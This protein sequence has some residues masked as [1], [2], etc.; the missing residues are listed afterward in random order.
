MN[1]AVVFFLAVLIAASAACGVR[2]EETTDKFGRFGRITLY[3]P[4]P[5]PAHVALFVSGDGG[6]NLGVVDMA[7]E[8]A[9]LDTLV[10]GVD[11]THYLKQLESASEQCVYPAADFELL[12]KYVQKKLGFPRYITPVMIGY[13]SGATL[14]YAALVQAPSN[15]FRGAISLSFC[16]DIDLSK[17]LCRGSGLR[18]TR[19]H[20]GKGSVLLPA[21]HLAVPWVVLQGAVDQVC[22]AGK[23]QDYVAQVSDGK[24]VILPKVGHGFSVRKNWLPQFKKVFAQLA[25]GS[26]ETPVSSS[27]GTLA[28]L[29]LVE[30]AARG[31]A[32]NCM[33]VFWSGDGGWADLDKKI[34]AGLADRGVPVVGVN[35]LKYFWA[36]RT[37][38]QTAQDLEHLIRHYA[39]E[40][41]KEK[42]VLIG[43]SQGADIL[44][45]AANRLKKEISSR[46]ELIVLLGPSLQADFEFHISNWL[47]SSSTGTAATVPE[48]MQLGDTPLLCIYGELESDS[49]CPDLHGNRIKKLALPGAHHFDGN[50]ARIIDAILH[51]LKY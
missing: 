16:P 2:A 48:I 22:D 31:P 10:V 26:S 32:S 39:A 20:H 12:S 41:H 34:S 29:P 6:W 33:A 19:D 30:V 23:A 36:K 3:Y 38:E 45:F 7:R 9:A 8:I 46:I 4:S 1:R 11:T 51:E 47:G 35:S 42:V 27:D 14:V 43:Y 21:S 37:P 44:P 17:P 5:H 24:I 49:A 50:Y 15:T 28:N 40:W 13:S 25:E 18:W